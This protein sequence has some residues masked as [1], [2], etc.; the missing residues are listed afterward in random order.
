M[1]PDEKIAQIPYFAHE[2]MLAR[3][4]RTIKRLSIALVL[5]I[6]LIFASNVIWLYAWMQYD[7]TGEE[8]QIQTV[9]VD[10]KEGVANY[11]GHNGSINNGTDTSYKDGSEAAST[12]T[13]R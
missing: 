2:G 1:N 4:D 13:E 3:Q 5:S 10:A 12:E 8:T 11:I 6:I 7:Y 9:D